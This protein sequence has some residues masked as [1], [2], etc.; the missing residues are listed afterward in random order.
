MNGTGGHGICGHKNAYSSRVKEG[1]W[2]E[3]KFGA[4]LSSTR[5]LA[6]QIET[7]ESRAT[8]IHPKDMTLKDPD[9][10][11]KSTD[12]RKGLPASVLFNHGA[13]HQDCFNIEKSSNTPGGAEKLAR[14]AITLQEEQ[15]K[16]S[17]RQS[18]FKSQFL[19]PLAHGQL[20]VGVQGGSESTSASEELGPRRAQLVLMAYDVLDKDHSGVVDLGDIARAYDASKHPA[21]AAGAKTEEQVLA[22]FLDHFEG[23][24]PH[25]GKLLPLEFESYYAKVSSLIADDDFFELMIR[26]A[27][28]I[29][30][31][32][33]WCANTANKRVLVIDPETGEERIECVENDLGMDASDPAAIKARLAQ[34]KKKGGSGGAAG[35]QVNKNATAKLGGSSISFGGDPTPK[36]KKKPSSRMGESSLKLAEGY[37]PAEDLTEEEEAMGWSKDMPESTRALL[38]RLKMNFK[39]RGADGINGLARKF[40]IVDDDGSGT[41]ELSEFQKCMK[42]CQLN[43]T[44]PETEELFK[45]FDED[46]GG[47]I[48]Y[49]EFL[50]GIRGEMN[51]RR[52]QL[53]L[54]AFDILDADKG[55]FVDIDD[56]ADKYNAKTNPDVISGKKTEKQVLK[57]FLDTFDQGEKDGKV[58]PDEFCK[59]YSNISASVDL[60]D[61]FELMIRNAWHIPGGEGWCANTAN[62][63]VLVTRPDGT[64]TVE[65]INNDMG[66]D[67]SDP[68]AIAAALTKQGIE[69]DAKAIQTVGKLEDDSSNK[70]PVTQPPKA[71]HASFGAQS[72]GPA[73]PPKAKKGAMQKTS[74]W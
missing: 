5:G 43:F 53:V 14:R 29:P 60:D 42:E 4:H 25:D 1:N 47:T 56:I 13:N 40:R 34:N 32:E 68:A 74:L 21:V 44:E 26:N 48:T 17:T 54:L 7:S 22:E 10:P 49:D 57:E 30:G 11:T 64:Q 67:L 72:S 73:P 71:K 45:F 59:Y 52:S 37:G 50:V 19:P 46:A 51:T 39:R 65:C 69:C 66:L 62:K 20:Q 6:K 9:V 24:G 18:E 23:D 63:R 3:D 15:F 31:G 27:W 28:H 36:P 61:Y 41:L 70:T 16:M 58:Y 8:L 38:K 33:G 2:V 55:G 35:P 12:G